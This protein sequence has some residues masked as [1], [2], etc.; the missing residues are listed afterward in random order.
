MEKETKGLGT[1][2]IGK[3]LIQQSTP[4]VIGMLVMALYNFIDSIFIGEFV[5]LQGLAAA[6]IILPILMIFGAFAMAFGVG[7]AS[8]ISRNIGA[9]A[10]DQVAK[11][12]GNFQVLNLSFTLMVSLISL[13]F[14][15]QLLEFFGATP[16]IVP[17]AKSYLSPLLI[18]A[19]FLAFQMGNN[20]IIRS[21]G[22]AK[23]SM[24]IMLSS[25]LI[26][27]LLDY[28]LMKGY[29]LGMAGAAW[30]TVISWICSSVII[31]SYYR[32]TKNIIP[33]ACKHFRLH[34]SSLKE[35]ILIGAPTLFRQVVGSLIAIL[36]NNYL[37]KY[38]GTD[39]L[40]IYG[41]VNRILQLYMMP[42]FGIVQGMQPI[43]GYNYGAKNLPRVKK[44]VF[45]S[46]K[47]LTSFTGIIS[48]M[49]RI[50]PTFLVSFFSDDPILITQ[51]GIVLQIVVSCFVLVGFQIVSSAM[52]QALGF[53]KKAFFLALLRQLL[54]FLPVFFALLW[55]WEDK[56]Q[57]IW[58]TFPV[59]DILGSI[60][61]L[62][63]FL[64][65]LKKLQ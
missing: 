36:I 20:N 3:L 44:V 46:V 23:V 53:V 17:L 64:P 61:T 37:R 11:V 38:G 45:L 22:H 24:K 55:L 34:L 5:G 19:V 65:D 56:L 27:L 49:Y 25:A 32:S 33:I 10:Y 13:A 2:A 4:A 6:G 42:I 43:I 15:P 50:F 51:T 35:I 9:K 41:I 47:L 16:E 31:L 8:I 14:I 63:I 54:L 29:G 57:A 60:L 39:A 21:V 18:G 52:Y 28:I 62:I 1:K 58:L 12:F 40:A 59:T 30:A 48:L 7:T 26:N